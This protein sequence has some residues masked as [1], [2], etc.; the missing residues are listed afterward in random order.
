MAKHKKNVDLSFTFRRIA[1]YFLALVMAASVVLVVSV[2]VASGFLRTESFVQS[3]Y[4]RYNDAL[5]KEVNKAM[6][7]VAE[8]TGLPAKAYTTAIKPGHIQTALHQAAY[9][10][11]KGYKTDYSDSTYLYSYYHAGLLNYCKENGIPITDEELN[12]DACFAVDVFN[13][14]VGD[15]S[16]SSIVIFAFTYTKNPLVTIITS[17]I[18][19]ILCIVAIDLMAFGVHKKYDYI[20]IS[21]ITGG[22]TLIVLPFFAI[23]MKYTST[24]HFMDVNAFNMGLADV[25]N[26]ILKIYMG[27]GAVILII[28][29]VVTVLNYHYY[30]HKGKNI[31]TEREIRAKIMDDQRSH[32]KATHNNIED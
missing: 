31:Q 3:R 14:V 1:C 15:E 29:I 2:G 7:G 4:E 23:I 21:L 19:F 11:V 5:L 6:E 17:I 12:K 10:T 28:G 26:D 22:E 13:S 8:E 24:L 32:Y 16:T 9:N 18:V 27:I 25:L 20:G 30:Y